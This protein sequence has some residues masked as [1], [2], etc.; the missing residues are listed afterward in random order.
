[1][2][3]VSSDRTL[4]WPLVETEWLAAHLA[5][6]DLRILDCAILLELKDGVPQ[7]RS[8]RPAWQEGH[9]PGSQ[10]VD[11]LEELS[12]TNHHLPTMAP[13][14]ADFAEI[15]GNLGVGE[16]T[17]VVLY[18]RSEHAWAGRVWWTLRAAGFDNAAV[19]NGGWNKWMSESREV[20]TDAV[21]H[22]K[23]NFVASPKPELFAD[24]HEVL[25]SLH[26]K[27]VSLINALTPDMFSG[28]V[29]AYGRPGRI[30]GSSNVFC[31]LVID[32]QT[33]AFLPVEELRKMF[34]HTNAENAERV[35]TYCGSGIAASGDALALV[36]LGATNVAVYDGSLAEWASDPS[37]PLEVD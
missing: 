25:A 23:A 2:S 29:N 20:S 12:D 13:P 19:L 17:K 10:Y 7:M 28:K 30:P 5:D 34:A 9:I 22:P 27:S 1:M 21:S 18:D 37:L 26:N 35:I 24:K 36:L 32:P 15:M 31:Q 6:P 16:G 8:G 3:S 4:P 11:V 33:N 14:I